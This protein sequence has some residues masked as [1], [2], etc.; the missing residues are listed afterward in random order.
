MKFF[1]DNI[2]QLIAAFVVFATYIIF[3]LI[4]IVFKEDTN[5]VSQVIIASVG[6]LSGVTGYYYG[7]SQGSAKK[8]ESISTLVNKDNKSSD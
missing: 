3:I 7:Y 2:K 1:A 4:L 8:D 6:A 5:A